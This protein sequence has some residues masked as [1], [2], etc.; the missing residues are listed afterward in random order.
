MGK[1]RK[2]KRQTKQ[3]L[4]HSISTD[5][6]SMTL[7]GRLMSFLLMRP[8]SCGREDRSRDLRSAAVRR[9]P[10][11]TARSPSFHFHMF[12]L[13]VDHAWPLTASPRESRHRHTAPRD[14]VLVPAELTRRVSGF[15]R[16]F[17]R[18]YVL[19]IGKTTRSHQQSV[20]PKTYQR[21][22]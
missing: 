6:R 15:G 4:Q 9:K 8:G 5:N 22:G 19:A 2:S 10:D 21:Q 12:L 1:E 16:E 7:A 13:V 11:G 14:H 20:Y 3:L 17:R 18:K